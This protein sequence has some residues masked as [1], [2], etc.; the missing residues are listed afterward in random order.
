M[1]EAPWSKLHHE[2]GENCRSFRSINSEARTYQK[3]QNNP[4]PDM[5]ATRP[6]ENFTYEARPD[7]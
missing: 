1:E 6:P 3:F 7:P 2:R 4:S 5:N